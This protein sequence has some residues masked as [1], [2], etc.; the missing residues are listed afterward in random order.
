MCEN[1]WMFAILQSWI[2]TNLEDHYFCCHSFFIQK[3]VRYKIQFISTSLASGGIHDCFRLSKMRSSESTRRLLILSI[4][5]TELMIRSDWTRRGAWRPFQLDT[6]SRPAKNFSSLAILFSAR[7]KNG[8][9]PRVILKEMDNKIKVSLTW[10]ATWSACCW[11]WMHWFAFTCRL[12]A[13]AQKIDIISKK[14]FLTF[15]LEIGRKIL[16]KRKI[17]HFVKRKN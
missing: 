15:I 1:Y 5:C 9:I 2:N 17:K 13:A 11:A 7:S 16:E 14:F 4:S 12:V 3:F 10:Y 8:K 6:L